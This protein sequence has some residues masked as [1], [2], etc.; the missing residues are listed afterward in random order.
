MI[1]TS[2]EDSKLERAL[3]MGADHGINSKTQDVAKAAMA[4]TGGRGVDVVIE[5]VGEVAFGAAGGDR[6]HDPRLRRPILY[7]LSYSRILLKNC[8]GAILAHEQIG[9]KFKPKLGVLSV[10]DTGLVWRGWSSGSGIKRMRLLE[11]KLKLVINSPYSTIA[12]GTV[13][14]S[15]RLPYAT[16]SRPF[17]RYSL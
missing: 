1:V 4:Y 7:P 11:P 14:L 2:R 10:D 9:M 15:A 6:T 16:P 3:A 5:N 13:R 17:H 8:K 12:C